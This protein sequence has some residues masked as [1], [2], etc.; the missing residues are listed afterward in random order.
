VQGLRWLATEFLVVAL[1]VLAALVADAT[2]ENRAAERRATAYL[3]QLSADLVETERLITSYQEDSE[4][5][6][7]A[8]SE[9]VQAFRLNDRPSADS[10]YLLMGGLVSWNGPVRPVLGTFEALVASG[11][12]TAI[13]DNGLRIEITKYLESTRTHIQRS[14][15]DF[16]LYRTPGRELFTGIDVL[17]GLYRMDPNSDLWVTGTLGLRLVPPEPETRPFEVIPEDFFGSREMYYAVLLP[18]FAQLNENER[19]ISMLAEAKAMRE[20]IERYLG[21]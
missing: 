11:D 9:L 13:R 5:W 21:S 16:E 1:G 7:A 17:E 18:A 15:N 4:V 3:T 19:L 2:W 6:N 12:L 8:T 10:L 20:S 14:Q